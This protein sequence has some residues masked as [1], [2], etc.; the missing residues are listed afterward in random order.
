MIPENQKARVR[1][2]S[3]TQS[4]PLKDLANICVVIQDGFSF[5]HHYDL[6]EKQANKM[7]R[8][9]PETAWIKGSKAEIP[10]EHFLE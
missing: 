9:N 7:L 4:K 5:E 2:L 10:K 1:Q 6:T 3:T 8:L